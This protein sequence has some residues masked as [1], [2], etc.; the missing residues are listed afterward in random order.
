M[1]MNRKLSCTITLLCGLFA[2][3]AVLSEVIQ[4]PVGQQ[5]TELAQVKRPA[6]GNTKA[7][8]TENFGE[9][10]S[11]KEARGTPPISSWEYNDFVVYF[12]NDHVI[13][14]VLKHRPQLD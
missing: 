3:P 1:T 5:A 2:A 11:R 12:E 9:P 7:Q 13:H 8:V 4:V 10:I 6:T 14:S